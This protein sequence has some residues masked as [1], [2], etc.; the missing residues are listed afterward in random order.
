MRAPSVSVLYE[1]RMHD[2]TYNA[3]TAIFF[4]FFCSFRTPILTMRH[5]KDPGTTKQTIP[6][7]NNAATSPT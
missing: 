5:Y 4:F 6:V 1:F 3:V 7:E 2:N